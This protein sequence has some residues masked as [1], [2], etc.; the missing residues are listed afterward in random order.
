[1][2]DVAANLNAVVTADGAGL[3]GLQAD[4]I[5]DLLGQHQYH[6]NL[7]HTTSFLL[8]RVARAT[9]AVRC[10]HTAVLAAPTKLI[11]NL[12]LALR[13]ISRCLTLQG[14]VM[15]TSCLR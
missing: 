8:P 6:T 1:V 2:D 3:A 13:Q 14:Y 12:T 7:R 5:K 4:T 10:C 15:P 11:A 9:H